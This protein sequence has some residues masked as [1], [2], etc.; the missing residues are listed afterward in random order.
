MLGSHQLHRALP[1]C[2]LTGNSFLPK[3]VKT[4]TF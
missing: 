2:L 3:G 1:L 4:P